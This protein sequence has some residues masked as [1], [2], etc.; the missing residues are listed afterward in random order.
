MATR[1]SPEAP[2]GSPSFAGRLK[3]QDFAFK[4]EPRRSPRLSTP[5]SG[6]PT[7]TSP[8]P[9]NNNKRKQPSLTAADSRDSDSSLTAG[10]RRKKRP[11]T[12]GYAPPSAYAHLPQVLPDALAPNLI[13]MF[14]GLNPGVQT[15]TSGHAYAHPSNLFWKLLASSGITPVPCTPAEDGT[16]PRRFALGLT[17]IVSRPSRHGGELKNAE[18]DAGVAVLEGKIRRWRPE[19][20]CIVGKS[21]WESIWRVRHGKP[22]GKAFKYGWQD[23]AE[24]LGAPK[25]G[26]DAAVEDGVRVDPDWRGAKVFVATSTSGLAAGMSRAEKEVIWRELGSWVEQRRVERTASASG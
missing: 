16:L 22:V 1:P 13:L 6:S 4:E 26:E 20:V 21:I 15:A 5:L 14:C 19:A 17:N 11:A 8:F 23:E 3:L 25:P 18:L 7:P 9:A 10:S 12:S 2:A 24:N